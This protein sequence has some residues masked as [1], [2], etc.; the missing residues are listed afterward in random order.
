MERANLM[1]SIYD[2]PGNP[3]YGG[4]GAIVV[5]ELACRLAD[6]Y[7]VTV[8]S[9]SY[10]GCR[11]GTGDPPPEGVRQVFLR[12]GWAGS[13]LGQLLFHAVLPWH[14]ALRR[15]D[16]WLESFTPPFSTSFLPLFTR[17]PVIGLAQMLAGADATR[18]YRLPF[19]RVERI[20]LRRYRRVIVLNPQDARS[21]VTTAPR[22]EVTVL[23]NGVDLP[24]DVP[25]DGGG[26]Y[27][28]FLGRIDVEQKGLDLLLRAHAEAG[29]PQPLVIV[30]CGTAD[31][32]RRLA[33]LLA[34]RPGAAVRRLGRVADGRKDAVLRG[35]SMLVMPSRFETFG[36]SAL[37]GM[38]YGKP[39]LVFDLPQLEW[40][41]S[42]AV[43]RVPSFDVAALSVQL[44][45]LAADPALRQRL[46]TAGRA[47]AVARA[48]DGIADRYAQLMQQAIAET[49]R[50]VRPVE[51]AR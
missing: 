14:A 8:L 39:V 30:G 35:C 37:E 34:Q 46:G 9:G 18:R 12:V 45:R 36:L 31:Q 2:H 16:V 51:S 41:P 10:R 19:W 22:T 24:D 48:W 49:G 42:D 6:R 40:I 44:C 20:G 3:D 15:Y 43:V 5:R 27:I 23:T 4:G 29:C 7:Q 38:A 25:V 50:E 28:L 26:R 33:E 13:R 47:V 32:E 17:R 11:A 21:V 1:I